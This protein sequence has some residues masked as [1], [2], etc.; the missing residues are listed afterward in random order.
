MKYLL[1]LLIIALALWLARQGR[2]SRRTTPP[3]PSDAPPAAQTM[4]ACAHCGIHLPRDEAL[5]GPG[6]TYY[7]GEAHMRL[8]EASRRGSA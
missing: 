7:C 2:G 4:V 3:R 6:G 1:L 5:P 8:H